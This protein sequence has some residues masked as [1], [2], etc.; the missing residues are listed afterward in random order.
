MTCDSDPLFRSVGDFIKAVIQLSA[1]LVQKGV[2]CF[3]KNR[4]DTDSKGNL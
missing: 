3:P 2:L 1:E 4:E